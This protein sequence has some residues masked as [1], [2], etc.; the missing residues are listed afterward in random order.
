M[1]STNHEILEHL[2]HIRRALDA[3]RQDMCELK[4]PVGALEN[5]YLSMSSR[6]DRI[7]SRVERIERRLDLIDS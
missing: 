4:T 5:R 6:L 3:I 1:S 2:L 7:D